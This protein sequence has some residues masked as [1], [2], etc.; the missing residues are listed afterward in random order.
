[1]VDKHAI[2]LD[3]HCAVF[4]KVVGMLEV[5]C[6]F[7]VERQ[8]QKCWIVDPGSDPVLI[9]KFIEK[10]QLTPTAIIN[11]HGHADH[12]GAN[13]A[14]KETLQLPIWA[15]EKD[16]PMLTDAGKNLSF[17]YGP[18]MT[19]PVA[20]KLLSDG[21]I[22]TLGELDFE[23]RH[24]PGHTTGEVLIYR[25]DFLIVGDVLFAGSVGR[26]DLPGGDPESLWRSIDEQIL[27]LP[28]KTMVL[29]GHGPMTTV[30]KERKTNPFL[31]DEGIA[32]REGL[33]D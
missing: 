11:T 25:P 30:G 15:P 4:C 29:P 24:A 2:Y 9:L 33:V 10:L 8:S 19:S 17:A 5:N 32:I 27:T 3:E 12:I 21:E 20:D 16:A 14:L 31:V 26:T 22:V 18:P 7:I 28:D 23:I 1:M 13:R 6:Y